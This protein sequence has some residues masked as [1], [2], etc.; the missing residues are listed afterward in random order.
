MQ[1]KVPKKLKE[2]LGYYQESNSIWRIANIVKRYGQIS[3]VII[4]LAGIILGFCSY[5]FFVAIFII[6]GLLLA[7]ANFM[8]CL[9]LSIMLEGFASLVQEVGR[10]SDLCIYMANNLVEE[11]DEDENFQKQDDPK[12]PF[13]ET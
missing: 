2:C 8:T 6:S 11:K 7:V 9:V 3:S 13:F 10:L 1:H 12:K 4:A 5:D